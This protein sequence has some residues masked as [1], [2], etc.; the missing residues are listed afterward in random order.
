MSQYG[1]VSWPADP[2]LYELLRFEL[3]NR[4]LRTPSLNHPT[5]SDVIVV[6]E[7]VEAALRKTIS[8]IDPRTMITWAAQ[9]LR[10]TQGKKL[11]TPRSLRLQTR[12]D[13]LQNGELTQRAM[14]ARLIL[15]MTAVSTQAGHKRID[16]LINARLQNLADQAVTMHLLAEE[17]RCKLQQATRIHLT[18]R[19][20]IEFSAQDRPPFRLG[21]LRKASAYRLVDRTD[22]QSTDP[23]LVEGL[24]A[25]L[26][27]PAK[28]PVELAE[29][30]AA[31]LA[32]RGYN[33]PAFVV[34]IHAL[35]MLSGGPYPDN[36]AAISFTPSG[37]REDVLGPLA[38]A[39]PCI[40]PEHVALALPT[41]IWTQE[42]LRETPISI[43]AYQATPARLLSRPILEMPDRTLVIPAS[44]PSAALRT[45]TI[46]LLEGTW[47]E[48]LGPADSELEAAIAKRRS[49]ARPKHDFESAFRT[50]LEAI[51]QPF[52]T[53]INPS[54]PAAPSA[55]GVPLSQ[56][57]DGV[58]AIESQQTIWVLDAKDLAFP[59]SAQ[60]IRSELDKYTRAKGHFEKLR[61]KVA[62]VSA[63][64]ALVAARLG[65][66]E[67]TYTVRGAFVTRDVTPAAF[68]EDAPFPS[69]LL[70]DIRA[71]LGVK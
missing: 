32:S 39:Y 70:D 7:A 45:F 57:I 56:E 55:L 60:R 61:V 20:R 5:T 17:V 64:P 54:S 9:Y 50:E 8:Q 12:S 51:G 67:G 35:E 48:E 49:K 59:Y 1:A 47:F 65:A 18:K 40:D 41:L 30:S 29:V 34:A 44:A 62:E 22:T 69:I 46:R 28:L 3:R 31:L 10:E 37:L 58:I 68:L 14:G 53:N 25:S 27:D 21:E 33:L 23:A 52:L 6:A 24:I 66:E 15:E 4:G 43:A 38:Q 71:F 42:I 19:G 13:A 11:Q 16:P 36:A 26:S 63:D 2:D